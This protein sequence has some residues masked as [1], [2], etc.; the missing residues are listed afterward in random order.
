MGGQVIPQRFQLK[1]Q[2]HLSGVP[3]QRDHLGVD[4]DRVPGISRPAD[5]ISGHGPEAGRIKPVTGQKAPQRL[6]RI[7]N[8]QP[9]CGLRSAAIN[10][11][12]GPVSAA[13]R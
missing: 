12:T 7:H 11:S 10:A 2:R 1:C 13:V 9:A 6:G 8:Q 4:A 5:Q 3:Q